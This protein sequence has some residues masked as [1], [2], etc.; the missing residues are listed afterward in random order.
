MKKLLAMTAFLGLISCGSNESEEEK[1]NADTAA[2]DHSTHGESGA[3]ATTA[4]NKSMMSMMQE[5]MGQM[6][7]VQSTGNPDNDFAAL[8][9]VHHMG[10][11]DMAQIEISRGTCTL[12]SRVP[13][14][15]LWQ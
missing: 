14:T 4:S 12:Q 5:N 13:A 2:S 1:K 11:L 8:M 6:K 15:V 9:K 7:A 3:D 10:A